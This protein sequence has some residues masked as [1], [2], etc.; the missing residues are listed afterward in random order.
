M[1]CFKFLIPLFSVCVAA[2]LCAQGVTVR[3]QSEAHLPLSIAQ[4]ADE[5]IER[6][7]RWLRRFPKHAPDHARRLLVQ[8]ALK[9]KDEPFVISRCDLTPLGE[10]LPAEVPYD[11]LT[12]LT[13]TL[14]TYRTD[15][16]QLFALQRDLET[17]NPPPD[18]REQLA[19]ALITTQKMDALGGHWKGL[20]G[21]AWGILTLRALLNESAPIRLADEPLPAKP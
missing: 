4:E 5:A 11:A 7:E 19:L 1:A 2:S 16:K 13:A 18:W 20:E 17:V 21:T 6:A 8:Y 14:E 9:S 15:P 12:N 3:V 10:L